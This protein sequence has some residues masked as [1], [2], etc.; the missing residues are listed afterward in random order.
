MWTGETYIA[1][2]VRRVDSRQNRGPDPV[3]PGVDL[4]ALVRAAAIAFTVL[5]VGGVATPLV[6]ALV[7][8]PTAILSWVVLVSIGGFVLAGSR[9]GD[10]GRP[11]LH[12]AAAALGAYLLVLPLIAFTSAAPLV[13][14]QVLLTALAAVLVGGLAGLVA[15]RRRGP[16]I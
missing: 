8:T 3:L 11:M 5:V 12:G 15:G 4:S 6:A 14:W 1:A 2:K 10:A 13:W 7:P 16:V 9:I